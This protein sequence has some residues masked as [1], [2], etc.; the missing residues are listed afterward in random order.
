MR[1][2]T[3]L[4]LFTTVVCPIWSQNYEKTENSVVVT[5][6][7]ITT[8]L[9]FYSPA[10]VR[11]VKYPQGERPNKQSLSVVMQP[12]RIEI[13]I[14]Q[15]KKAITVWSKELQV[16][17]DL[18]SGK[19]SFEDI[20]GTTL[21]T[22]KEEGC[23]F[24]PINYVSG[25]RYM[26]RQSFRLEPEEIIYGLGQQQEGRMSQRGQRLLLRQ[27]NMKVCIP[28]IASVKG[29]GLF[30]D[31]YSPTMFAD[32]RWET[33]F[34]SESGF[35]ADY[36]FL[37]GKSGD[38]TV[39]QM[40]KLTGQAPMPPL[41]TFG[42]W[43]SRERYKSQAELLEVVK[44]YRQLDVPLDGIIQDW[45]YWST[46]NSQWNAMDFGN[47]EYPEPK[48]MLDEIHRQNAHAMISVWANFGPKT[49]PFATLKEKGMLLPVETWPRRAGVQPYDPYN[50]EARDIYWDYLNR[51][52]FSLGMDAWWLDSTEPDH[53]N[54][55]ERD[56]DLP[57]Y[58]GPWRD[59]RNA[60]P[61]LSNKGVY[62]HQRATTSDKRVYILTRSAF[63]GQQR[64]ATNT[65]SGD[66]VAGWD[67]FR[68]QISAGLNFGVCG[69]PYWNT[70]IGGFFTHKNYPQGVKDDAYKEL[71]VR[72]LQ[73]ATFTPMMRSHGTDTPREIY[74]FGKRG[75]WAF[76]AQEKFIK[77]RYRILP[78]LYAT[79]WQVSSRNAGFMR[80]LFMD[81]PTDSK[82]HEVDNEFMLGN[83][84]LVIPVTHAMY[85]DDKRQ[86]ALDTIG[87]CPVYLPAGT[88]W[89]DFWT[90]QQKEGGQI[91]MRDA[92]IDIMPL[93]VKAGSI[94]PLGPQV[95]YA[96]E[97]KWK[98]LSI[99]L[100]PGND[101]SFILYED[102]ND[103]YNY[104]KGAYTE[105]CMEW[106]E[107][108]KTLTIGS[109]TGRGFSGMLKSR[110]FHI[111]DPTGKRIKTVYYNGKSITL[112][113]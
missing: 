56:F 70:D 97:K 10:I 9:I 108:Q 42:F 79:A 59:V 74:Q 19:V 1:I 65:W 100:Y 109:R 45:Q 33:S 73:F 16:C 76:D 62:E 61:L 38:G 5:V 27:E 102:E 29:Y 86:V 47:F 84:F 23:Q 57:T 44:K 13:Q 2:F 81:F 78:Y 39:A 103:N 83:S 89:F 82:S 104:E 95:Q 31:N 28:Y 85:V 90:G 7:G 111:E 105:I 35:C 32:S 14:S 77:L 11:I 17:L 20:N 63:A 75:E 54:I 98:E 96:T 36:Y 112:K 22:E 113:L 60:F 66:V 93:Y 30:W 6:D 21:L 15:S 80:A 72:W 43:Q 25:R 88:S 41:W 68:K 101:A 53:F 12:E 71:Y 34:E 46:D 4:F 92:P 8:E 110:Q 55:S 24:I 37:Y 40:R 69:I 64:Y 52:I 106:N 49:K 48:V 26:V 67:V 91:V 107:A 50:P 94:I 18:L 51:G 87:K 99:R 58:L 3:L